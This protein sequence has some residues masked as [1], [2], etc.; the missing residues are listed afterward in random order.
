MVPDHSPKS[1]SDGPECTIEARL[2]KCPAAGI[3][4]AGNLEGVSAHRHL[5]A[6]PMILQHQL[7]SDKF[8]P[9][10]FFINHVAAQ[11]HRFG[12]HGGFPGSSEAS[13]E[14][15]A[16]GAGSVVVIGRGS[17]PRPKEQQS[18]EDE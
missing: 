10:A 4:P 9:I 2:A 12:S 18:T 16:I 15:Q 13:L 11:R 3:D 7:V 5:I 17:Q 1:D 14:Y 8:N 6:E